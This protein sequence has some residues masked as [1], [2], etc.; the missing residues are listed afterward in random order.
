M[1]RKG[2]EE[3]LDLWFFF[4][5]F[6]IMGR[7]IYFSFSLNKS[8]A[9]N[10]IYIFPNIFPFDKNNYQ[11]ITNCYATISLSTESIEG[12]SY[13]TSTSAYLCYLERKL[14]MDYKKF[15][16]CIY[17]AHQFPRQSYL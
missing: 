9:D 16:L 3:K 11:H 7:S 5:F 15:S 10:Q 1:G 4:F 8:F 17:Q 6:L 14:G 13:S 12:K 2:Q